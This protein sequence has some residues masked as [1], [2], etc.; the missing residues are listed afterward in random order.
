MPKNKTKKVSLYLRVST[1]SQ[2]TAMQR[3][4]LEAHC[5]QK[6]WQIV[7]VFE[8][9]GSGA[10]DDRA[11]LNRMLAKVKSGNCP[12][13]TVAV[14]R[15]DRMARSIVQMV[16]V[17][18]LFRKHDVQ[19]VSLHESIDTSTVTGRMLYV[20]T[21]MFGELE[22]EAISLRVREG[23]RA[24][25]RNGKRLG[26]PRVGFDHARLVALRDEGRSLR[27][28]ARELGISRGSVANYL[29]DVV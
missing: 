4:A 22:R 20:L 19:F 12:Y 3:E 8:D 7:E 13:D 23:L 28:F 24:A 25:R 6:G 14:F 21:A 5:R 1:G 10:R 27:E 17:L 16:N 11:E 26:R 18:E 9:V 15:F 2:S 29:A